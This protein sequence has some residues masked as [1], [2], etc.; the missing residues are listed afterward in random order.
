MQPN[1]ALD[2]VPVEQANAQEKAALDMIRFA[3]R[4]IELAPNQPQSIRIGVAPAADLPDGEYRAHMLFRAVPKPEAAGATAATDGL[5]IELRPIY[6]VTIPV[7]VRK[8]ALSATLAMANVA[9]RLT[10]DGPTLTFDLTRNGTRSAYGELRVLGA[11]RAE[12]LMV[13]KGLG[14]YP[15]VTTRNVSLRLTPEQAAML[16]GPVTLQFWETG[17]AGATLAAEARATL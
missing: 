3:P 6:G 8:G 1:G 13:M 17:E 15:E 14:V 7:I 5:R 4:R 2:E 12:P 11:G 9:K 10:E 16:A